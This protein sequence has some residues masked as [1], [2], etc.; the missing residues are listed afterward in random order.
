M[1][2]LYG[3]KVGMT[4]YYTEK[5]EVVPVTVVEMEPNVVFQVKTPEKDGYRA[6][7][8]GIGS[9]KPQRVNR[10]TTGHMSK[11]KKGFAK[12]VAEIRLDTPG[13]E[14]QDEFELG[15]E[16]RCDAVFK[17]GQKVDVVGTSTGK[18][19]A[20]VMKRHGMAGFDAGHGTHEYFRHGGSIGCRKFPGRV[21]KNKRM[22]GHMG[23]D[24]VMQQGLTVVAIRSEDNALLIKGAVPGVKGGIVLVRESTR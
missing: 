24:R 21:F 16:I 14:V 3:K 17:A 19:F 8:V 15:Q 6:V 2:A 20:G 13:R 1:K 5:G 9:Q 4:R 7:Q 11:A 10:A 22:G 12:F 23:T 18:G